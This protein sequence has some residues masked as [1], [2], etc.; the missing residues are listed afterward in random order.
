MCSPKYSAIWVG[1]GPTSDAGYSIHLS[2]VVLVISVPHRGVR[3]VACPYHLRRQWRVWSGPLQTL[4]VTSV[5]PGIVSSHFR[6]WSR[7]L[8]TWWQPLCLLLRAAPTTPTT[9]L[10]TL[11][12]RSCQTRGKP[13]G[14]CHKPCHH[15]AT[16]HTLL[17]WSSGF[18]RKP[19]CLVSKIY[20]L[21][22]VLRE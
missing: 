22:N 1:S 17:I 16:R 13:R 4:T 3:Q 15:H 5:F 20:S 21:S 10:P 19:L 14:V 8:M 11:T 2:Y 7:A 18:S 9:V 6:L 12:S